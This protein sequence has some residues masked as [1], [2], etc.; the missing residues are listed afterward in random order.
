MISMALVA[1]W[2]NKINISLPI[3]RL[4]LL[5][6]LPLIVSLLFISLFRDTLPH[7]SGP[8]F[9]SLIIL[10]A[11]YLAETMHDFNTNFR[12]QKLVVISCV[13]IV[14]I[15]IIATGLINYYPGTIGNG[16]GQELGKGDFSL[17]MYDWNFFKK[18]FKITYIKNLKNKKTNTT[19]IINNKW[20]P[21][22]HI[23][24]YIAQSLNLDF[25]AIGKIEDIHTY[26]WLNSFRKKIN[27]GDDAYFITVSNNYMDPKNQYK[28]IFEK[29]N[30]PE[31][32]QQLR[33][34]KPARNMYVYL[35]EG[36]K[37]N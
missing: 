18:E 9:I 33:N 20:F 29:I 2:K 4:L 26:K 25:I 10:T 6:S 34:N 32:I 1:V 8:A 13:F 16:K 35:L 14:F 22:A 36:Y 21:G 3:K 15:S 37:G 12:P 19:F 5:L 30:P 17:D 27:K 11:C 23:D 31:V 7:W 24:N 28:K